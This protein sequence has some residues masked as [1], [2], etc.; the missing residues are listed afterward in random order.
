MS[1]HWRPVALRWA[2]ALLVCT[3]LGA[4]GQAAFQQ[5]PTMPDVQTLGP[6]AGGRVP[7]FTLVDQNGRS[8]TLMSL[9]GP[10]GVMLVFFRSADW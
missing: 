2:A 9:T 8:R 4:P 5:Q 10:K 3:S 6:Q 1:T 7:D